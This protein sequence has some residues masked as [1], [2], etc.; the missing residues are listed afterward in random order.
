M[1]AFGRRPRGFRFSTADLFAVTVCIV[2]TWLLR[3]TLDDF[4]WLLPITLGHFF[5][6]CNVFRIWRKYELIWAAIFV[7]NVAIWTMVGHFSWGRVLLV[8]SP[9][10]VILIVLQ[11]R[12]DRYHGIFCRPVESRDLSH[13]SSV[14]ASKA[15]QDSLSIALLF[16]T[17]CVHVSS[18]GRTPLAI[19]R[20]AARPAASPKGTA[21]PVTR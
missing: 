18:C 10:T 20:A 17:I 11:I 15:F 8:Q 13:S 4:V 19:D 7:I 1:A 14:A 9:V 3:S 21:L 12:S 6:F 5:L 2:A 16:A